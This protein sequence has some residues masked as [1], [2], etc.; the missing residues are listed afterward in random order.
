[1]MSKVGAYRPFALGRE[2]LKQLAEAIVSLKQKIRLCSVC[3]NVTDSEMCPN[4]PQRPAGPYQ[5]LRGGAAAGYSG[6]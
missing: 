4:L 5:S 3:F 1:M 2:D 6:N